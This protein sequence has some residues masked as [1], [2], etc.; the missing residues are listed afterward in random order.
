MQH[1]SNHTPPYGTHSV[2]KPFNKSIHLANQFSIFNKILCDLYISSFIN[3]LFY[4]TISLLVLGK[5][6]PGKKPPDPKPIPNPTPDPS[7]GAFFR[8]DFFL[9]PSLSRDEL[10]L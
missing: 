2:L 4:K 8:E 6:P 7:L 10:V 1:F 5:N 9:T 3:K